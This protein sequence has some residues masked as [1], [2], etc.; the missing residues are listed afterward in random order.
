MIGWVRNNRAVSRCGRDAGET[1]A[2]PC[3]VVC[4][5]LDGWLD[6]RSGDKMPQVV[7]EHIRDCGA[8]RA[9]VTTWN[10][11]ELR[12]RSLKDEWPAPE[13]IRE[14]VCDWRSMPARPRPSRAA[15]SSGATW[16][17]GRVWATVG[18]AAVVVV[19]GL[20]IYLTS[21]TRSATTVAGASGTGSSI[22]AEAIEAIRRDPPV[23]ATR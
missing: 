12:I 3:S 7:A 4:G 13:V 5:A 14:A 19:I 1:P 22:G 10:A 23:A 6:S 20:A 15:A 18:A 16:V 9:Y 17:G 11:V 21:F 8:C 2:L